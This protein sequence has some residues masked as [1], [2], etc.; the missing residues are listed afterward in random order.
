M[1]RIVAVTV[2]DVQYIAMT[3]TVI[4]FKLPGGLIEMPLK[5]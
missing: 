2:P 5:S 4:V 3:E 1:L